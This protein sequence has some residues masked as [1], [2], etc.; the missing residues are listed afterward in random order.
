MKKLVAEYMT[1]PK[2]DFATASARQRQKKRDAGL[3]PFAA[4][5]MTPEQHDHLIAELERLRKLDGDK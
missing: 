4:R 3:V 1:K 5:W 2:R